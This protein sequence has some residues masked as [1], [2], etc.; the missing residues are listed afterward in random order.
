MLVR[1]GDIVKLEGYPFDQR[2]VV[3]AE[4]KRLDVD[5][6]VTDRLHMGQARQEPWGPL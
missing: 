2:R 3:E 1:G 4:L 5:H 6:H